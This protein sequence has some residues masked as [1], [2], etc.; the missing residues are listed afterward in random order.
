MQDLPADGNGMHRNNGTYKV[1]R[2]E[3]GSVKKTMIAKHALKPDERREYG[4]CLTIRRTYRKNKSCEDFHQIITY[5]EESGDVVNNLAILQY[6]FKGNER[7][8]EITA[9]GNKKR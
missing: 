2:N 5:A 6:V 9:H 3:D 7:P 8:F 4:K 1:K